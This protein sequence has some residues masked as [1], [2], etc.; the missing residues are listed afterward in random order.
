MCVRK[1]LLAIGLAAS[2]SALAS[3]N[4]SNGT[5][6]ATLNISGTVTPHTYSQM[7]KWKTGDGLTGL[8]YN[9]LEM[10]EDSK[11]LTIPVTK[12]T[13]IL[14]GSTHS[15]I[16]SHPGL[17]GIS[18]KITFLDASNNEVSL[19]QESHHGPGKGHLTLPITDKDG[20]NNIGSLKVNVLA[21]AQYVQPLTESWAN[22]G[23][24]ANNEGDIYYGGLPP[25]TLSNARG[26]ID[27]KITSVGGVGLAELKSQFHSHPEFVWPTVG[28]WMTGLHTNFNLGAKNHFIATSY[29]LIMEQ[30]QT[31]EATFDSSISSTTQWK[32]RLNISV[33][34]I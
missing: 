7:W 1:T 6:D 14:L 20:T 2:T 13:A 10:T 29:G 18:P 17:S 24:Y 5:F 33:S 32:S 4:W 15:A 22:A 28:S 16:K 19:I 12:N 23:V 27:N 21:M 26:D 30:G 31:L 25:R 9:M 3:T 8:N 34:Y 11:K